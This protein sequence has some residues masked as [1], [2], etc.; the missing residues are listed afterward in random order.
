MKMLILINCHDTCMSRPC[1]EPTNSRPECDVVTQFSQRHRLGKKYM[2]S[3]VL[4]KFKKPLLARIKKILSEGS[5]LITF[6]GP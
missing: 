5:S 2:Y 4:V 3:Y 1:N 6:L